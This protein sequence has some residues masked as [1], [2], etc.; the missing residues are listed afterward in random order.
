MKLRCPSKTFLVGE[1]AVLQDGEAIV[2]TTEPF[3][4]ASIDNNASNEDK[5]DKHSPAARLRQDNKSS[6]GN[7]SYQFHDP[8]QGQGGFGASTAD[9]L[10]SYQAIHTEEKL[11]PAKLLDSYHQYAWNGVGTKPSGAD[12]LAQT[13]NNELCHVQLNPIALNGCSWPFSDLRYL[14]VRTGNKV[15]THEHLAATKGPFPD[16][17]THIVKQTWQAIQAQ[18]SKNFIDCINHYA[19]QLQQANL[20]HPNTLELLHTC[21]QNPKILAAKGCGALGADVLLIITKAQDA[22]AVS[23]CYPE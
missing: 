5:Q 4:T 9:F 18:H 3:F 23:S 14:L 16:V 1:Y 2:L 10:L 11:D 22:L 7:S 8:H 19:E 6:F 21:Q 20:T 15:A 13:S 17:L 12:L